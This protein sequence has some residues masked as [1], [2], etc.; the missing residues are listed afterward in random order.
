MIYSQVIILFH[1]NFHAGTG[2]NSIVLDVVIVVVVVLI[3]IVVA[4]TIAVAV[5]LILRYK[6]EILD[7]NSTVAPCTP[8][9]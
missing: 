9:Y 4:G 1:N 8:K 6:R 3:I 5:F 7:K 2:H